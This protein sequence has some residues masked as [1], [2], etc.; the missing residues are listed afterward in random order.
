MSKIDDVAKLAKV[1]KGTVSNVYSGKRP[2]SED[3]RRR[4]F[5]AARELKYFPNHI[6]RS[7][8]TKETMI[9][10][11]KIPFAQ[12]K[13]MGGLHTKLVNGVIAQ[14][15]LSNYRVLIDTIT[16]KGLEVKHLSTDPMDGVI[17]MDPEKNDMRIEALKERGAP[18]VVVG[19]PHDEQDVPYVNNNN[20]E[21]IYQMTKLLIDKGHKKILFLNAPDFKTVSE[22]RKHGFLRAHINS[23]IDFVESY[24][25]YK[26]DEYEDASVYGY[27]M[28]KRYMEEDHLPFTA[29]IADTDTVAVGVIKA[30]REL[31]LR[32]PEDIS[33]VA[34]SDDLT[35]DIDPPLT[36][37]SLF[38][39]RLGR[40]AVKLLLEQIKQINHLSNTRVI[41]PAHINERASVL[42]VKKYGV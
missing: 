38:P 34:L 26:E 19:I 12:D 29:I 11:L 27:R 39:E 23:N 16:P 13:L 42:D 4:V 21:M 41:V 8:V 31:E 28:I 10:G 7:L 22:D 40:E 5:K 36:T 24:N 6:A 18:F 14:A 3:V 20:E 32:I 37:I 25:V 17:V 1:S 9:I 15:A 33:V 30:L 35:Y 2:T